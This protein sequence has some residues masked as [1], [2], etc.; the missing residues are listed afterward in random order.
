MKP[1]EHYIVKNLAHHFECLKCNRRGLIENIKKVDCVGDKVPCKK[2]KDGK[3]PSEHIEAEKKETKAEGEKRKRLRPLREEVNEPKENQSPDEDHALSL[4]LL[5]EELRL[6][7]LLEEELCLAVSGD[8]SRTEKDEDK[9][10]QKAIA[11]SMEEMP[12]AGANPDQSGQEAVEPPAT[13]T[14]PSQEELSCMRNLMDMGFSKLH[15]VWGVKRAKLKAFNGISIN[16]DLAVQHATWRADADFLMAKRQKLEEITL[17]AEIEKG[18]SQVV[19]KAPTPCALPA[20]FYS[21]TCRRDKNTL[22]VNSFLGHNKELLLNGFD[23]LDLR[24][25]CSRDFAYAHQ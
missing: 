7:Q 3:G 14:P 4:A 9:E 6:Q 21:A 10:V 18:E 25:G 5:E 20:F 22:P 1:H 16:L 19:A 13:K 11:L 2:D 17:P 24:Y 15:A 12:G 23:T 8:P